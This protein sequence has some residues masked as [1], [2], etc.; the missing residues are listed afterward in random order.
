MLRDEAALLDMAKFARTILELMQGIDEATFNSDIRTQSAVLYQLTILGEAVKRL[1]DEFRQEH[2]EI[3][4][5]EI[6]GMR[7]KLTHQYDR[8]KLNVVW[9]TV[10]RDIPEF[11]EKLTPLLPQQDSY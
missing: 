10:Q 7:D 5:R 2:L 6:A 11:L 1:S 8:V 3:S 9:L 4:W